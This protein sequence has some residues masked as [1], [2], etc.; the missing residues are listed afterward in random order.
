[1]GLLK[2]IEWKDDSKNTIVHRIDLKKDYINRG[3]K[4][5]VRES[6]VCIFSDKG[7]MADVFLP[8]TYTLE[9]DNIPI[10]TKL[11]SWKY[12]FESPFKSDV[13]FVNTKQFTGY[14]WGTQNPIIIRDQDF[15][16]VRVRGFGKYSFKVDDAYVFMCEL[17]GTNSS[18]KTDDI[19]SWVKSKIVTQIT[20]AI[21]ES[22][23]PILDM[24]SNLV[25]L[26]EVVLKA[27]A[28]SLEAIGIKLTDFT[29]ENFSLPPEL[30]KA[31]DEQTKL[32]MMRKNIDVYTQM[33][34]VEALKAAA[35]NPGTA[36]TM[37]GAG[38][39]LGLGA[40]MGQA[41][42][43]MSKPINENTKVEEATKPCPNC[44]KPVKGNPKFCPECGKPMGRVCPKCGSMVLD[45]AKF[46]PECGQSLKLECP[47]C[48]TELKPGTK[49]CP[50]C[51]TKI[52]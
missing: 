10:I 39:G 15:G 35:A 40:N 24:A 51:G 45:N 9:T 12:G 23:T 27:L 5:I 36:G 37:M 31:L 44:G 30:E 47:N 38:I 41:F 1:M 13:F 42:S 11:L 29:F 17:S 26:G 48:K 46:C 2:I 28:P 6:Q 32:G 16:A 4:L 49:F 25:E 14:N 43:N 18:Y 34:Q 22:K 3:S 21:G 20:D 8:G 19:V 7:R 33:G 50:E 52:E